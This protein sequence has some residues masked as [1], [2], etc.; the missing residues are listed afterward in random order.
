MEHPTGSGNMSTNSSEKRAEAVIPLK[1]IYYAGGCFWGVEEYFSRIPGV[2]DVTVGYANGN[3]ENPTYREVCSG[4]TGHAETVHVLYDPTTISLRTLTRQ[5]FMIINPLSYNKQGNDVGSQYRTGIYF[6]Q[7]SDKNVLE[8]VAAEVQ[9]KYSQPLAVELL[10]LTNYYPAEE[11]HQDYLRKNPGGYC[12]I[13]FDSLKDVRTEQRNGSVDPG[14][15]S[16]PPEAEL[17][18][19]LAPEV[20]HV[21]RNAGTERAF[22]GKYLHN[23]ERGIYVDAVTGEPLFSSTDKYESGCGWPSFTRPIDAAVIVRREDTSFGMRRTEVRSRVGDS[24][25]GHVFD[26]GPQDK[27]GLRYCINSLSLRFIPYADMEKE[28]YGEFK[29][30]IGTD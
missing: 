15:Y 17:Q 21:T 3:T 13:S 9:K 20:Y 2:H 30:L 26:D 7:D 11:Y 14:R 4:R 29:V 22:S 8:E 5:F 28:G 24:H 23:K 16:R 19:I 1:E 10:P 6:T 18:K 25:L 12:H 27:G